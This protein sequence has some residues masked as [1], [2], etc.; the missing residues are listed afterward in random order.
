MMD[1]DVRG[2]EEDAAYFMALCQ[3]VPEGSREKHKE[4]QLG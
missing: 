1:E 3:C 2:I 4:A